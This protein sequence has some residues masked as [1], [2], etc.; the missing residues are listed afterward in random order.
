MPIRPSLHAL[1]WGALA[2]A[3]VAIAACGGKSKPA[4]NASFSLGGDGDGGVDGGD[5]PPGPVAA[6]GGSATPPAGPA[7]PVDAG[8][9]AA[10]GGWFGAAADPAALAV[11]AEA[12][13]AAPGMAPEGEMARGQLQEGGHLG[14][15]VTMQPGRCYTIIGHGAGLQELD[16]TLLAPP[17]Y[18]MMAGQDGMSGATAIIG[19]GKGAMCPALPVAVPYKVDAVARKGAGSVAVQVYSKAK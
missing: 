5:A 9:G 17:F 14:F 8:P 12:L 18:T 19:K 15:L 16:L 11:Q 6:D 3:T 4:A 2:L 7:G 13:K 1:T 10:A